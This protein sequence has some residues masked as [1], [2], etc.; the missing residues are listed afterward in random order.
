MLDIGKKGLLLFVSPKWPRWP[1]ANAAS[2][3]TRDSAKRGVRLLLM[4]AAILDRVQQKVLVP[5]CGVP[6]V[7]NVLH[8]PL[9]RSSGS[10]V[11]AV[12]E[13]SA[14]RS[15]VLAGSF[16]P[17]PTLV[18]ASWDPAAAGASAIGDGEEMPHAKREVV[19]L[20]RERTV[21]AFVHLQLLAARCGG[22]LVSSAPHSHLGQ[23][24]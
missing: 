3:Y 15:E 20:V 13:R 12:K 24:S 18:K 7:S 5:R 21:A 10:S 14:V 2:A 1:N 19:V 6:L 16:L 4:T 11:R 23:P 8:F 22:Q 17:H 9:G